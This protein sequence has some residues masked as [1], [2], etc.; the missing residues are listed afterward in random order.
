[1]RSR[2]GI[3]DVQGDDVAHVH[4]RLQGKGVDVIVDCVGAPYLEKDLDCLAN[5]GK[6]IF[7]GWMGGEGWTALCQS[8]FLVALSV[9]YLNGLLNVSGYVSVSCMPTLH[10]V[11]W[12]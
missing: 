3:A 2:P 6:V 4:M 12:T 1:M 11:P 8:D 7:I 10:A 5:D 9:N